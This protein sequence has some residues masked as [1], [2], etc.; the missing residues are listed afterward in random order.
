M[1]RVWGIIHPSVISNEIE[2][3]MDI[4]CIILYCN[5]VSK[6]SQHA[7]QILAVLAKLK[8]DSFGLYP[9]A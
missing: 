7:L 9:K 3:V 6:A 5:V 8:K 2:K 4:T 1:Q